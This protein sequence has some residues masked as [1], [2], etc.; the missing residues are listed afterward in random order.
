MNGQEQT[1]NP[2]NS[3]DIW[4]CALAAWITRGA[5][6]GATIYLSVDEQAL[7][8]VARE[9]ANLACQSAE[10]AVASFK[11]SIGQRCGGAGTR[12]DLTGCRG[13]GPDGI[14]RC[15]A[16]LAGMVFAAYQMADD[17]EADDSTYFLRLRQF[18][19]FDPDSRHYRPPGL[20]I[21]PSQPAPE[22]ALWEE[23]NGWL[24]RRGFQPTA[25]QGS[26]RKYK[27]SNY[28]ISQALLRKGDKVKLA[29]WFREQ[30][31]SGLLNQLTDRDLLAFHLREQA[32]TLNSSRLRQVLQDA[33]DP[34]YQEALIDAVAEVYDA[35]D[36]ALAN[37]DTDAALS[38][39]KRLWAGLLRS[40]EF[41][42]GEVQYWLYPRAPRRWLGRTCSVQH[43]GREYPLREHRAGWFAPLWSVPLSGEARYPVAGGGEVTELVLPGRP[44]WILVHDPDDE[45]SPILATWSLPAP[46][47]TFLLLCQEAHERQLLTLKDEALLNWSEVVPLELGGRQWFEYRECQVESARWG[48]ILPQPGCEELIEA[49]RPVSRLHAAFEGGL[50]VPGQPVWLEGHQPELRLYRFG[51]SVELRV[52]ELGSGQVVAEG[53]APVNERVPLPTLA[54]GEYSIEV[55]SDG[56]SAVRRLRIASWDDVPARLPDTRYGVRMSGFRLCGADLEEVQE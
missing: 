47:Q 1:A 33:G 48:R 40:E 55:R 27:Y 9:Y 2:V 22:E 51:G 12:L 54:I 46:G 21:R 5:S 52:I 34:R 29:R 13:L 50:R 7:F 14:P 25:A 10:E 44:F 26:G 19:G 56:G 32:G 42:T 17:E 49:L 4:N 28:P 39:P 3:Y 36:W 53:P 11:A 23:W 41:I 37:D 38:G 8:T 45:S 30:V 24:V 20:E 31:R 6:E 15:V 18:F 35:V 16:F 43:E